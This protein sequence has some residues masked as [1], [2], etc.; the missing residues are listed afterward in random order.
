MASKKHL[1]IRRLTHFGSNVGSWIDEQF[2]AAK[3]LLEA[4]TSLKLDIASNRLMPF[5]SG[6]VCVDECLMGGA[7]T[8]DQD[9][10]FGNVPD[11]PSTPDDIVVFVVVDFSPW[12][13]GGCAWHPA[14]RLGC[15]VTKGKQGEHEWKL[16]HELGHVLGLF[17]N[18]LSSMLMFPSVAWSITPPLLSQPEIDFLE[19][20]GPTPR[21]GPN[22]SLGLNDADYRFELSRIE[23]RYGEFRKHGAQSI[24]LLGRVYQTTDE[25]EYR[26]RSVFAMSQVVRR[27]AEYGGILQR[28]ALSEGPENAIERRAA[29]DA[30]GR[31]LPDEH[32]KRILIKLQGDDDESVRLI[33]DRNLHRGDSVT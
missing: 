13:G 2:L 26:A 33:A 1:H 7:S 24:P 29:A 28:A 22:I 21:P 16:A 12:K 11:V 15:M 18:V 27:Y 5:S 10:L 8:T 31:L 14:G 19:G 4:K 6:I 9:T 25:P 30:A 3:N 17:H 20:T 32:A 23:P